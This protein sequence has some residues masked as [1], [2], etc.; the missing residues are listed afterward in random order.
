M[1]YEELINTL[2]A[3]IEQ[4][5]KNAAHE[6][7]EAKVKASKLRK[8]EKQLQKVAEILANPPQA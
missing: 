2:K 5:E 6:A 7:F 1:N 4:H 3:E 8:L